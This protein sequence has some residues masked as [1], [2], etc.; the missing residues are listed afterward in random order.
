[1]STTRPVFVIVPGNSYTP[2]HYGYL[3]HLL[4]K[5]GY[6]TISSMLPSTGPLHGARVVVEDDARYTRDRL[7]RPILDNE[8]RDV[9]IVG[10][11][12][13]SMPASAAVAGLDK[14]TRAAA[15]KR[16]AVIGQIYIAAV[17]PKGGDGKSLAAAFGGTMPPHVRTDVRIFNPRCTRGILCKSH[18]LTVE[19]EK[20]N[21]VRCDD[22]IPPMMHDVEA[23]L[24]TAARESTVCP[25]MTSF[26]SPVPRASWDQA[27]YE[28]RIAYIKTTKDK[29]VPLHVQNMF[30]ESSGVGWITEEIDAS[31]SPSLSRPVELARI[32]V[33]LAERFACT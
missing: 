17:I 32:I 22:P 19:K 20:A 2:A 16:T 27:G 15:G 21:L 14:V 4:M 28:G 25:S 3:Q 12:Y 11:S 7:V 29:A 9:I 26:H 23:T 13:S 30:I 8:N 24:A 18:R 5:A 6:G 31:H 10:H 33:N 1:M